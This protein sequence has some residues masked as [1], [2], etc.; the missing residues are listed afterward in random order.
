MTTSPRWAVWAA[1]LVPLALVP[2]ALWRIA[3]GLGVPVGFSGQ[4]AEDFA[5]PGWITPYVI[6][7][8]LVA[9][10]IALL[11]L[12]LVRPWGERFPGWLPVV[13]GR[14]VPVLA[15]VVPAAL[16]AAAVTAATVTGAVL[17]NG[18]ENNGN[19]DAPQ[20]FAGLVM[21]VCY[22]PMLLWGPLLAAVT[23]AYYRRRRPTTM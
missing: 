20:G 17:W 10:G 11:T 18:P 4:L 23:V 19:P 9:E 6:V 8:S 12:G 16:G 15:A 21:T 7:L 3:Q 2:S 5:A 1:H 14:T 13:G 22:A